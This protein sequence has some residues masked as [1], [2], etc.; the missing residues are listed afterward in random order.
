MEK[1]TEIGPEC[2]TN[3]ESIWYKGDI[4]YRACN[5]FVADFEDGGKSFCVKRVGHP[6]QT[7]ESYDGA[8]CEEEMTTDV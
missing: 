8:T 5:A 1:I 3:G 4:Y 6:S 2:F 7:H